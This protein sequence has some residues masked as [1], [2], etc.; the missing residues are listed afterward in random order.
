MNSSIALCATTTGT[1]IVASSAGPV[2]C[3]VFIMSET[4]STNSRNLSGVFGKSRVVPAVSGKAALQGRGGLEWLYPARVH[5][6]GEEEHTR[7]PGR[8]AYGEKE[9]DRGA[10][11][12]THERGP[13]QAQGVHHGEGIRRHQVVGEGPFVAS[14]T[15]VAAAVDHDDAAALADEGRDLVAPVAAVPKTA[16]EQDDGRARPVGRVPDPRTLM[17]DDPAVPMVRQRLGPL[18]LEPLELLVVDFHGPVMAYHP[19]RQ[20]VQPPTS[21]GPRESARAGDHRRIRLGLEAETLIERGGFKALAQAL[22]PQRLDR[23]KIQ[24]DETIHP[25]LAPIGR[26]HG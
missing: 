12:P 20:N 21:A 2:L 17:E 14:A 10:I 9:R 11:A 5:V 3:W 18:G 7:H 24:S 8:L 4:A 16:V 26:C 23:G 15:P 6:A 19:R 22:D 25:Q 13:L 1:R